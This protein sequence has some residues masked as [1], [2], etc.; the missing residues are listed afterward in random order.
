MYN[1]IM[2]LSITISMTWKAYK[3]SFLK[4]RSDKAMESLLVHPDYEKSKLERVK[5]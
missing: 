5:D 4:I 1:I 2:E 3:H